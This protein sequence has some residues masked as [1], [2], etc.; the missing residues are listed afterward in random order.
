MRTWVW[1]LGVV[2]GC[3]GLPGW[4][5]I[6]LAQPVALSNVSEG[7][8][9]VAQTLV[10]AM[11]AAT[12]ADMGMLGAA[13]FN[14]NHKLPAGRVSEEEFLKALQFP[15]DEVVVLTLKG[16]QILQALERSLDLYPQSNSAF[17]QLAGAE[18]RFNPKAET[19]K[20]VVSVT[21]G[22]TKL[23][24]ESTYRVATTAS[25][26]RGA[27]GYFRVWSKDQITTA[28]G[29]SIGEVVREYLSRSRFLVEPPAWVAV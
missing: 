22:G 5:Q 3:L 6:T 17:L 28:T 27:L 26:A 11:R 29:R 2:L 19:G 8:N 25:L 18:V 4:A 20:R 7:A 16:E 23:N 1:V 12:N 10:E 14:E 15:D 13:F 24:P 9:P 21:I